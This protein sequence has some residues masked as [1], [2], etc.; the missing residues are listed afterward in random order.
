MDFYVRFPQLIFVGFNLLMICYFFYGFLFP[1]ES[2]FWLA[3]FGFAIFVLE[4]LSMGIFVLMWHTRRISKPVLEL[5]SLVA[6][7]VLMGIVLFVTGAFLAYV[8]FVLSQ[9][10]KAAL[11][12][13]SQEQRS[14]AQRVMLSGLALF[15]S[16][17]LAMPLLFITIQ[18]L[19]LLF[20][21]QRGKSKIQLSARRGL[22]LTL[23]AQREK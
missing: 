6:V 23:R 22:A 8:Y 20:V 1:T 11:F 7:N 13:G 12:F 21:G 5:G 17:I 16:I 19:I 9:A 18:F 14:D 3:D 2:R 10:S 15:V 4:F